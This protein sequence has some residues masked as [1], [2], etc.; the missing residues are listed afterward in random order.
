MAVARLDVPV[1]FQGEQLPG[2]M[3]EVTKG[4]EYRSAMLTINH[5]ENRLPLIKDKIAELYNIQPGDM[6]RIK[7]ENAVQQIHDNLIKYELYR[8]TDGGIFEAVVRP[9]KRA[10]GKRRPTRKTKRRSTRR[11]KRNHR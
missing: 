5:A 4:D 11:L 6:L 9:R 3:G 7:S 2:V 1:F 8:L 10:G